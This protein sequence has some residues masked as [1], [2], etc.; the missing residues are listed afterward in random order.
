MLSII[1]SDDT[2]TLV[3]DDKNAENASLGEALE[4]VAP[5]LLPDYLEAD[6]G[7]DGL[8]RLGVGRDDWESLADVIEELGAMGSTNPEEL[9]AIENVVHEAISSL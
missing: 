1:R 2:L 6:V 8:L 5:H 4:A 3:S 9:D 7:E